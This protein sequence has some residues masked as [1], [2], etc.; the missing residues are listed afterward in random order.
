MH[1]ELLKRGI[2]S[3]FNSV[4][5]KGHLATFGDINQLKPCIE[6]LEKQLANPKTDSSKNPEDP[7]QP[8]ALALEVNQKDK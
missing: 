8:A 1:R 5:G 3:K 6:F 4:S 7:A 2:P